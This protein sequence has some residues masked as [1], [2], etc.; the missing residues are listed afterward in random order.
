ME[1][2]DFYTAE[3]AKDLL[4]GKVG[5][6]TRDEYESELKAYLI[7]D[8]IKKARE[9]M[10]LT[11][12][13]LGEMVGVQRAQISKIESGRNITFATIARVFKAMG[14]DVKLDMGSFGKV[15]LW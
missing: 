8:A 5:T 13:Q 10:N 4:F 3:E 2:K 15:A 14:I 6:P 9:K 11:Q 1:E 12:S 7:G